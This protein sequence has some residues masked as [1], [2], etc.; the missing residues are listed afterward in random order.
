MAGSSLAP[1]A[2]PTWRTTGTGFQD[3][4][5][6]AKQQPLVTR[7]PTH[8][9]PAIAA[10]LDV[11]ALMSIAVAIAVAEDLGPSSRYGEPAA[12]HRR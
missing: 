8:A 1:G 9:A 7:T 11:P 3:G 12:T 10:A 4:E 2:P 6:G 5:R